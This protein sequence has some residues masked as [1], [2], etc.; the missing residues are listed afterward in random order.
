MSVKKFR[1]IKKE[2][3]NT[4]YSVPYA[5]QTVGAQRFAGFADDAYRK[6]LNLFYETYFLWKYIEIYCRYCRWSI[7]N[8]VISMVWGAYSRAYSTHT[9]VYITTYTVG[10]YE[11]TVNK[12]GK[13]IGQTRLMDRKGDGIMRIGRDKERLRKEKRNGERTRPVDGHLADR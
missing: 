10:E 6:F 9:V 12:C 8:V 3:S 13:V 5:V 11:Q 1:K 4:A 7:R 2:G